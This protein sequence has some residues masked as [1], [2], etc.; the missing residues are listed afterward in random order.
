MTLKGGVGVSLERLLVALSHRVSK[1]A[2]GCG[3]KL[4]VVTMSI[5]NLPRWTIQEWSNMDAYDN[6]GLEVLRAEVPFFKDFELF[7][8]SKYVNNSQVAIGLSFECNSECRCGYCRCEDH[9]SYL[10]VQVDAPPVDR[11]HPFVYFK[12]QIAA[13]VVDELEQR[14]GNKLVHISFNEVRSDSRV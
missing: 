4:S 1:V 7:I 13:L 9:V 8:R 14:P 6:K 12:R 10:I 11:R 5:N 2:E 3:D